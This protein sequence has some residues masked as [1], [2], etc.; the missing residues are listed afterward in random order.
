METTS[1]AE[2]QKPTADYLRVMTASPDI[3]IADP[4]HNTEAILACYE[5]AKQ[6]EA[7]L[8]AL[9]ELCVT[10]YSAADM[11]FNSEV[12]ARTTVALLKLAKATEGGPAMVVGA[13]IEQKGVL[14]NCAVVLAEGEVKGVV[15]KSYLPNYNEFYEKRWFTSGKDVKNATVDLS[16]GQ[17]PFGTDLLFAVNG[18][19][20]GL[21]VCEDAWAPIS[22]SAHAA[23]AGAEVIVNVSASN[24]LI[25]KAEYR[26]GMI[27]NLAAKLLCGYIYTSA[28]RGESTA[29]VVY[30]GHQMI[31]ENGRMLDQINELKAGTAIAD[32]DRQE[33][34]AE[35]LVNKTF[36]DQAT[37]ERANSHYRTINIDIPTPSADTL[38]R[39]VDKHPFV[40]SNPETLDLRCEQLFDIMAQALARRIQETPTKAI[41]I[42]LSGG[43]DST[44]ALLTASY[45]TQKLGLPNSVIHTVTMPGMASSVRTQDNATLLAQAL[46]TT[47]KV[48]P[49]SDLSTELLKAIGH[50][51]TT[52]DITYENAQAR[53]RTTLLMNYANFVGGFVQGTGDMSES[54]QGWCTYNGDHMS[55]FNPNTSIP[56]TLVKHLVRWY[57]AKKVDEKTS[58]ILQDIVSTPVS[59]ELTGKGALTQ[60][61]EDI[62]GPYEL[63]DFFLYRLQRRRQ[64]PE[65]IGYLATQAFEGI[66]TEEEI[67][68]WLDN[69]LRRFT[70]SQWKRDV[71]PNGPKVGTVSLSPRGDL[72]M[73]P[74]TSPDWY[75]SG[76]VSV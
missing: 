62:L 8:L 39:T 36:A 17:I 59:P 47:H 43:L 1:I 72:R 4:Q 22:P 38:L 32:I 10:G 56:K 35:R 45:A 60:T 33:I 46:G 73:A 16:G 40:P 67:A 50:D 49:I 48:L 41:V 68:H 57:G 11:L 31:T 20:V 30:G 51:Q 23:L 53:M 61:T 26:R 18:T 69:F 5:E 37:E 34:T 63:H 66:Y 13:P 71:M 65:K 15:P 21:E 70:G 19:T 25:G 6:K 9:P 27:T 64:T 52:E 3:A 12:L 7:E 14:Y 42:G 74:N 2:F 44:L 29:D 58:R 76:I 54:A 55:M 28:G 75:K 24:E